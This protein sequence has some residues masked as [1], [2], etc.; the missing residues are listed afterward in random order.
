MT[1]N[2][3][4]SQPNLPA[5]LLSQIK[6]TSTL[7]GHTWKPATK[8][9]LI[10]SQIHAIYSEIKKLPQG[11]SVD[12]ENAFKDL[13]QKASAQPTGYLQRFLAIFN[14][15][16]TNQA[17]E[18]LQKTVQDYSYNLN[19]Q[20]LGKLIRE[21]SPSNDQQGPLSAIINTLTPPEQSKA[22][23]QQHLQNFHKA[24][25][26]TTTEPPYKSKQVLS[27][28][29]YNVPQE[30][31]FN[32]TN[33][34]SSPV[35]TPHINPEII[36]EIIPISKESSPPTV[37]ETQTKSSLDQPK[38]RA[39]GVLKLVQAGELD[40]VH[41]LIGS[42]NKDELLEIQNALVDALADPN[43]TDDLSKEYLNLINHIAKIPPPLNQASQSPVN[44]LNESQ[45][46][47]P[48]F[49]KDRAGPLKTEQDRGSEKSKTGSLDDSSLIPKNKKSNSDEQL[50]YLDLAISNPTKGKATTHNF[51]ER[52]SDGRDSDDDFEDDAIAARSAFSESSLDTG[53]AKSET[54]SQSHQEIDTNSPLSTQGR[55]SAETLESTTDL[56]PRQ[57][58]STTPN[59]TETFPNKR[60]SDDAIAA[61]K[62]S[63][64][65]SPPEIVLSDTL[66]GEELGGKGGPLTEQAARAA[67]SISPI[68]EGYN[69]MEKLDRVSAGE[70]RT[71]F[72]EDSLDVILVDVLSKMIGNR[73]ISNYS[74]GLK[75]SPET[76]EFGFTLE[77]TLPTKV[78]NETAKILISSLGVP[79]NKL[80]YVNMISMG[81]N[82][83]KTLQVNKSALSTSRCNT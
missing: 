29:N 70:V 13:L 51:T 69:F 32:T 61:K 77:G 25:E 40:E 17:Q 19:F 24:V 3:E 64:G 76:W 27:S 59:L 37:L 4:G 22:E 43:I 78:L 50:N 47:L 63:R 26:S 49:S 81:V 39:A 31:P 62:A 36:P 8:L 2:V 15:A 72:S 42:L 60:D 16:T 57:S 83:P 66:T 1:S 18:T 44:N 23:R 11:T 71:R 75:R 28:S 56:T 30:A 20:T 74:Y 6:D 58:L 38:L 9:T 80:E 14:T 79:E 55:T 34:P 33:T 68:P 53:K 21:A 45:D 41:S 73:D 52:L 10:D 82:F 35:M 12:I 5:T 7:L 67:R 48:T 65:Q 46:S 54:M